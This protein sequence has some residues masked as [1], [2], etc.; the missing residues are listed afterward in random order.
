MFATKED[1][2]PL[3]IDQEG[4]VPAQALI[5][6]DLAIVAQQ[7]NED[8]QQRSDN[9]SDHIGPEDQLNGIG[10]QEGDG[11]FLSLTRP[12]NRVSDSLPCKQEAGSL[13]PASSGD[14]CAA[15]SVTI[16]IGML[17][18]SGRWR[19]KWQM[20]LLDLIRCISWT[21]QSACQFS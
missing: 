9:A 6:H 20:R 16:G 14:I 8:D 15:M 4:Q 10:A 21:E 18:I 17:L 1:T 19:C 2:I 11:H 7:Q 3:S 12:T 13:E 5:L